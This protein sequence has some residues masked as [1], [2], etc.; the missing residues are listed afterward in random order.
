LLIRVF[1][2]RRAELNQR[3]VRVFI[4]VGLFSLAAGILLHLFTHARYSEFAGGFLIGLSLVLII[5]GVV[6]R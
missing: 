5:A 1:I 4:P 6:K 3:N 2:L